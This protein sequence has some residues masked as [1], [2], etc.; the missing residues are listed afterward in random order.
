MI[1][2]IINKGDIFKIYINNLL[3]LYVCEPIISFQSFSVQD[4]FYTIE[5]QTKNRTIVTE[6]DCLIKWTVILEQL[7]KTFK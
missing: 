7:D 1:I 3:H 5:Y 6:Y 2:K 4:K